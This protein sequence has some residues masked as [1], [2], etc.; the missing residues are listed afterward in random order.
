MGI[1]RFMSEVRALTS[2]AGHAVPT[3][4]TG[5]WTKATDRTRAADI[6]AGRIP[7]G[8]NALA[9]DE[10]GAPADSATAGLPGHRGGDKQPAT[11]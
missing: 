7:C 2:F 9:D 4:P 5:S 11:V 3:V 10:H 6:L 1:D 8:G